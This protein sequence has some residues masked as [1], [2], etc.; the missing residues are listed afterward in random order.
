MQVA[1]GT[2]DAT[3]VR[4]GASDWDIAGAAAILAECGIAFED[5]C[6]GPPRLNGAEIRHGALAATADEPLKPLLREALIRVYGCPESDAP[7][8]FS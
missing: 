4:R 7:R 6:A 1:T 5:A 2:I 8:S 3:G